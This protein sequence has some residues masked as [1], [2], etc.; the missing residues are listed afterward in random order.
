ML[1]VWT[2]IFVN[3]L[4]Y[5]L[6]VNC[7]NLPKFGEGVINLKNISF[8][9]QNN[10]KCEDTSDVDVKNVCW[11]TLFK[12]NSFNC[13]HLYVI[14]IFNGNFHL[15][16]HNISYTSNSGLIYHISDNF[17]TLIIRDREDVKHKFMI[18]NNF[19]LL[20]TLLEHTIDNSLEVLA[21]VFKIKKTSTENPY[22]R[23]E[24]I[25]IKDLG[26]IEHN[27]KNDK[28]KSIQLFD[29]VRNDKSIITKNDKNNNCNERILTYL[30]DKKYSYCTWAII[31]FI[32][33]M[34]VDTIIGMC[35]NFFY[36]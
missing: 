29:F 9:C 12:N 13:E 24:L 8:V 6:K 34:I 19:I 2:N 15:K 21:C 5:F 16:D 7:I 14:D 4:S 30:K 10:T 26:R 33:V 17:V 3:V 36:F 28:N 31:I 25:I 27:I 22:L 18:S 20:S 35:V 11:K 32:I 1:N 23:P